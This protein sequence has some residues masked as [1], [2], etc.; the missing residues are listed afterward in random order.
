VDIQPLKNAISEAFPRK[1]VLD[2]YFMFTNQ[3]RKKATS[4]NITNR[5]LNLEVNGKNYASVGIGASGNPIKLSES[6]SMD[7]LDGVN[8]RII[9]KKGKVS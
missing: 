2:I 7:E 4:F 9:H 5:I 3:E 1:N 8:Y 6:K